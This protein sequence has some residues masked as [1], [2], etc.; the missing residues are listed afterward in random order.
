MTHKEV[1]DETKRLLGLQCEYCGHID[2]SGED[3]LLVTFDHREIDWIRLKPL[4]DSDKGEG[5]M[6]TA[7]E[8]ER[9]RRI[10]AGEY[11]VICRPC[12]EKHGRERERSGGEKPA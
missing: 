1:L 12:L 6:K 10:L 3:L 2:G 8:D 11:E 4:V 7:D 9:D 5:Q